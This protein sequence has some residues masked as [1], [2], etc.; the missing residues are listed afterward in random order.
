M[1]TADTEPDLAAE[2]HILPDVLAA[3]ADC[4]RHRAPCPRCQPE[5]SRA[6]RFADAG[7]SVC[8]CE[9][10]PCACGLTA[11]LVAEGASAFAAIALM[12]A[13]REVF[14]AAVAPVRP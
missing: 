3:Q 4:P 12:L 7:G 1:T 14:V 8:A 13:A 11:F 9:D 10:E 6:R 5:T 2:A